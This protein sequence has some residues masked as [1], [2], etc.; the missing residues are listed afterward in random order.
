[1][2]PTAKDRLAAQ[3][4]APRFSAPGDEAPENPGGNPRPATRPTARTKDVRR[5]V[6]LPPTRHHALA[7]WCE[8]Q[9]V[10]LGVARVPGQYVLA[11]LVH[12]LLS[13]TRTQKMV[14]EALRKRFEEEQS[15]KKKA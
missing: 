6:D 1:M 13:D 15:R 9:A 11:E 5:T 8:G 14:A 12:L 2:S 3:L 10:G 7:E 4:A